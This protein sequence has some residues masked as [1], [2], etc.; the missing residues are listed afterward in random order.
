MAIASIVIVIMKFNNI[1]K[2]KISADLF[3]DFGNN[4]LFSYFNEKILPHIDTILNNKLNKPKSFGEYN[5]EIIGI[6]I[7]INACVIIELITNKNIL[8]A[9]SIFI[10]F[11]I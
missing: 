7:K 10:V 5:L 9:E 8:L 11:K 6:D 1:L 4:I 3:N 2:N